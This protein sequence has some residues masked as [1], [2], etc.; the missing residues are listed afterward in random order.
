MNISELASYIDHTLLLPTA[1]PT[2]ILT[3]CEEAIEYKTS[4]VCINSSYIPLAKDFLHGRVSIC[5]VIGF[6]LG[7][8]STA[9]KIFEA[10]DAIQN[11]ADEIDMVIQ[12]GR[13]KSGEFKAVENEIAAIKK[14]TGN[15]ILKV[16]VEICLLTTE[17]KIECCHIVSSAGADFIKTSTGFSTGGATFDDVSLFYKHVDSHVRI[18]AAGGIKSIE[19]ME[20]FIGLGASRLGTSSAIRIFKSQTAGQSY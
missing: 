13:L 14:A 6:P 9:V 4:S 2:E 1:K 12:I 8:V 20:R 19:D 11:G 18:K 17:E 3:L 7:A 5:T 10:T 16:I 15:K